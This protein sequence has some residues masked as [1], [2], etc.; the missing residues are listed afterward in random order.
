[1]FWKITD[2]LISVDGVYMWLYVY[3]PAS[4]VSYL[5][6]LCVAI[7]IC[8][9]QLYTWPIL[10][11][12]NRENVIRSALSP[13]AYTILDPLYGLFD[14]HYL[15]GARRKTEA[16]HRKAAQW[17]VNSFDTSQRIPVLITLLSYA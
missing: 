10:W 5:R 9:P 6:S 13:S 3:L 1:M 11:Q 2:Q 16:V 4:L 17:P 15:R 14:D 7:C 8:Q 12:S